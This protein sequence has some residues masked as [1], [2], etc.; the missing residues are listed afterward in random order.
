MAKITKVRIDDLVAASRSYVEVQL[1]KADVSKNGLISPTEAKRLAKDLRDNFAD[2][3]FKLP[4]GS[5]SA[6]D[7]AR[8]FVVM[9]EAWA[10]AT[11][12]N[13]DGYLS[14]AEAK[15]LPK[16]L[17]DNFANYLDAQQRTAVTSGALTT[18]DTTPA[19]RVDQHLRAFG[20][21]AISYEDA[22]ARALKAVASDQESGLPAFAR[23]FGGPDGQP[24]ED[25][26]KIAAEVERLLK[27][28][29][30]ELVPVGEEIPTGEENKD[31]WIFSVSTDGQG[32]HGLWAII[33][34]KTGEASV[35]NFN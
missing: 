6:K 31:A 27:D 13:G 10:K 7:V 11:D 9:M 25:E 22:F 14:S 32:D 30:M 16:N 20:R 3:Q 8:E 15:K 33:D 26:R 24:L 5:V 35:T 17:R 19:G 1:K 2:S 23:E 28:G 12:K 34:R 18:R 4:A 29:S 21:S